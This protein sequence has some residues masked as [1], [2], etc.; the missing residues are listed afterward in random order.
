VL[1]WKLSFHSEECVVLCVR[2][3]RFG[4]IQDP[5]YNSIHPITSSQTLSR[6]LPFVL[7]R[8][9]ILSVFFTEFNSFHLIKIENE[10]EVF[11]TDYILNTMLWSL[12]A[13]NF[14][15]FVITD[16][17]LPPNS[18]NSFPIE[19]HSFSYSFIVSHFIYIYIFPPFLFSL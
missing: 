6:S 1:L 4:T 3:I 13:N 7:I 9:N 15:N 8:F 11:I 17:E 10:L 19:N 16:N 18:Y 12:N 5:I 2:I 14:I